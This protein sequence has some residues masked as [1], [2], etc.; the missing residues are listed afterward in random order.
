[1]AES[2]DKT[3]SRLKA[4]S[5]WKNLRSRRKRF[6]ITQEALMDLAQQFGNL[7]KGTS[8]RSV[9]EEFDTADIV[10]SCLNPDWDKVKEGERSPVENL[11]LMIPVLTDPGDDV[12]V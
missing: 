5:D 9:N 8:I 1:M 11:V 3:Q 4:E 6:R 2:N 10:Y 12:T 7:P